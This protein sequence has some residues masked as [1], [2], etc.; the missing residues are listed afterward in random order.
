MGAER[1]RFTV[2]PIND[3]GSTPAAPAVLARTPA[4]NPPQN[5]KLH[6][7]VDQLGF[8]SFT[9]RGT[10]PRQEGCRSAA[11]TCTRCSRTGESV[12]T[13]RCMDNPGDSYSIDDPID[14]SQQSGDLGNGAYYFM[15]AI[16]G[17]NGVDTWTASPTRAFPRIAPTCTAPSPPILPSSSSSRK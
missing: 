15:T 12:P 13:P 10:R 17:S 6:V 3:D 14:V 4:P 16:G 7:T 5:F 11:T 9:A 2:S 1:C 8:V